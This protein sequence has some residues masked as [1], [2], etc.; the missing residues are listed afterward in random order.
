[1]AK[2]VAGDDA[3]VLCLAPTQ[4]PHDYE[5]TS[6]DA[7]KFQK[8]DL[9]LLNGLHLEKRKFLDDLKNNSGNR[10][11]HVLAVG[12]A[13]PE[14]QR[15]EFEH[16]EGEDGKHEHEHGEWDPH[17][18]LGI[19]QAKEMV[20]AICKTLSELDKEHAPGF[21]KRADAYL[22]ELDELHRYGKK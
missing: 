2:K 21:K 16:G 7:L 19:E 4:E 17:A 18:W 12:E 20:K 15:L 8:A 11:L 5:P 13:V 22:Q 3:V 6:E 14:K 1:F 9:F 10:K